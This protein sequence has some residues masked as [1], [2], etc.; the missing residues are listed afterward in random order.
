MHRIHWSES[1]NGRDHF[2][3]L[4]TNGRITL[5]FNLAEAGCEGVD[6]I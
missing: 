4:G 5:K 2:G 3:D 6:W 1:L